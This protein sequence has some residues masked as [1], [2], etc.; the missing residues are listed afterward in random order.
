MLQDIFVCAWL[1]FFVFSVIFF[2]VAKHSRLI[3]ILPVAL[4]L[5]WFLV[6][7]IPEAGWLGGSPQWSRS[8]VIIPYRSAAAILYS[9]LYLFLAGWL[10][11]KNGRSYIAF[12]LVSFLV[13]TSALA[14]AGLALSNNWRFYNNLKESSSSIR[15]MMLEY[16]MQEAVLKTQDIQ[17]VRDLIK[18]GVSINAPIG[19][20]DFSPL[21]GAV[22][23]ENVEMLKFLL[24]H[25]ANP[26]G[27]ELPAAA[28]ARGSEQS[29]QMVKI[30]LK[31]GVDP[32]AR[33]TYKPTLTAAAYREHEDVVKLLL[34]QPGIKVN[35]TD[36]DGYTALMWA[37]EK[38]SE[39]IVDELLRAG[40]RTDIV[41]KRGETATII[42]KKEIEK[43]QG[44][45][46]KLQSG[47]K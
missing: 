5:G 29:L 7:L 45:L 31:A 14:L 1:L 44:I 28:F 30:L 33:D 46:S 3:R 2:L 12:A 27:R 43:E 6:Y 10:R 40:A 19:C 39:E 20:G 17:K 37:V 34:A 15:Q 8:A 18:Q 11:S 16:E 32:N 25:G 38:G 13:G 41:N 22:L 4:S 36:V 35:E 26:R 9:F 23:R 24:S 47:S 21:D 42:A